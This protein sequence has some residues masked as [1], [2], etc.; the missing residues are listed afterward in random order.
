MELGGKILHKPSW[1]LRLAFPEPSYASKTAWRFRV[2]VYALSL[3]VFTAGATA[4]G[5]CAPASWLPFCSWLPSVLSFPL[6]LVLHSQRLVGPRLVSSVA[7]RS[8]VL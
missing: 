5:G 7:H 1:V 3:L 4:G 2:L 6:Y 8:S